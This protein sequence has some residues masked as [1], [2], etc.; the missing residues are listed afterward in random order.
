MPEVLTSMFDAW[1]VNSSHFRNWHTSPGRP[2]QNVRPT[3]KADVTHRPSHLDA[4]AGAASLQ[5]RPQP[6]TM[7]QPPRPADEPPATL[8]VDIPAAAEPELELEASNGNGISE[9]LPAPAANDN[10]P[11]NPLPA[12]GTE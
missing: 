1:D 7:P 11:R 6:T 3:P 4:C 9:P 2:S 10:A 12:T 5:F 8:S